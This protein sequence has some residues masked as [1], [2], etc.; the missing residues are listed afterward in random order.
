MKDSILVSTYG[1]FK[2]YPSTEDIYNLIGKLKTYIKNESAEETGLPMLNI[3]T[4]DSTGNYIAKVAVPV[5]KRLPSFGNIT[6]K[7]MLAG[8]NILV[9]EV[10]GGKSEI[11]KAFA[12]I[13]NYISDRGYVAPAIPFL[14]LVT[15]RMKE[16]D[17]SKWITR[18]YYPIMYF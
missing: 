12:Q 14:S 15:D 4:P 7:W 8:G 16:P 11:D 10:K 1:I 6:Y 2:N 9:T 5:N 3:I 17:S 13:E 18:I